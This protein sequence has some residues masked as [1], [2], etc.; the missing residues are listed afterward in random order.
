MELQTS[1]CSPAEF[2]PNWN[3]GQ[4]GVVVNRVIFDI[5]KIPVSQ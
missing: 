3:D 5:I 2:H 4:V 1:E